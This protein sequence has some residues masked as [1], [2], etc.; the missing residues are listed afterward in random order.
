MLSKSEVKI[1]RCEDPVT[2]S[3]IPYSSS[4][5]ERISPYGTPMWLLPH[6]SLLAFIGPRLLDRGMWKI[7]SGN[8]EGGDCKGSSVQDPMQDSKLFEIQT[9]IYF[10][11]C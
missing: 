9:D 1:L 4:S 8:V 11:S 3:S 2:S 10:G 7:R 5:D 6:P